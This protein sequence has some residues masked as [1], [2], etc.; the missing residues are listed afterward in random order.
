MEPDVSNDP[1]CLPQRVHRLTISTV[2]L[3]TSQEQDPHVP[4]IILC[5][6]HRG[7]SMNTW[8]PLASMDQSTIV[9]NHLSWNYTYML[10]ILPMKDE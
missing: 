5:Y 3:A 10:K 6:V 7:K 9:V 8:V 2:R 4:R 1:F